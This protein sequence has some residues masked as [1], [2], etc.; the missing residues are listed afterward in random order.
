MNTAD[1]AGFQYLTIF[2]NSENK[3]PQKDHDMIARAV[4]RIDLFDAIR[5][6]MFLYDS[7]FI[8]CDIAIL[9]SY[10]MI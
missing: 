6:M 1:V 9:S 5:I 4:Q 7:M 2:P 10:F 3:N 8:R